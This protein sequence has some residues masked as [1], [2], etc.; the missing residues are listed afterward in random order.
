MRKRNP[1]VPILAALLAAF[2]VV[3][4]APLLFF[5]VWPHS[6]ALHNETEE[7]KERHLLLARNLGSA[8]WRYY[9]DSVS[10]FRFITLE[11][12]AGRAAPF[13]RD[14]L[15]NLN[16][17]H[18][19]IADARSGKVLVSYQA[20]PSPCPEV[21][22]KKRFAAFLS[23][24]VPGEIT[25]SPVMPGP[26][27]KPTLYLLGI[28]GK[29]LQIA[30]L[31]T[32]YFRQLGRQISFGRRGHAAIVDHIGRV[33]AHPLES[34]EEEMRDL[35][36]VSA[37]QRMMAGETGVETFYSPALKGEMIAGLTNVPGPGWGVMV[38]QPIAELEATAANIQ[39]SAIVVLAAGLILSAVIAFVFAFGIV[40][41]LN[42]IT[43][44]AGRMA[45]GDTGARAKRTRAWVALGEIEDL[46]QR[47][48]HMAERVEEAQQREA[49]LRRQAEQ[50]SMAKSDFLANVSHEIRTP[51][52][53][54][55]GMSE[56]LL[57]SRL[58]KRQTGYVRT[59]TSSGKALLTLINDILDL[60]K[61]EAGKLALDPVA[62]D[63]R[64]LVEDVAALLAA[65]AEEKG[66]DLVIRFKPG[67]PERLIGDPGRIR[68]VVTNLAGNA[69]KFTRSGHVLVEVDGEVLER[70]GAPQARLTVAVTDTGE[71]IAPEK[72]KDIFDKFEQADNSTTRRHG[73]T[74]L[75]LAISKQLVEAMGGTVALRSAPGQGSTFSFT[76][77]LP[78]AAQD[79]RADGEAAEITGLKLLLAD[80]LEVSRRVRTE[81]LRGWSVAVTAVPTGAEALETLRRAAAAGDPFRLA[82]LDADL[83]D[84]PGEALA[85]SI[86]GDPSVG[87]TPL[88]L[89][90]SS[91]D[92]GDAERQR[93]AGIEAS[94]AK[95][96]RAAELYEL[97]LSL[98]AARAQPGEVPGTAETGGPAPSETPEAAAAR[99]RVLLAEDNEINRHLVAGQL[100][101]E[102]YDLVPA[103]DGREALRS[104]EATPADFDLILMDLSMPE[105][106]GYEATE[107]IRAFE[108][109]QGLR[110][111]PI[112]GLTARA[113]ESDRRRCLETGMDDYLSKPVQRGDLIATIRKWLEPGDTAGSSAA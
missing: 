36:E 2:L 29:T 3:G 19:C 41:S 13:S 38:P 101:T 8:L 59:I 95:P 96:E 51:M 48:D 75:G 97:I 23:L 77:E 76:L 66:L 11:L 106:D 99:R 93:E 113:M 35:S 92:P 56:L 91:L 64:A 68:Q 17:R 87:P 107:A 42:P 53:G 7:V 32:D 14:L 57:R 54:I 30:A 61:V 26:G 112:V 83:P 44:A 43:L 85:R 65:R 100:E 86:A 10:A 20:A 39:N 55:L 37:V 46:T 109:Q 84:Q 27:G 104:Y 12:T 9:S 24:A 21:V 70:G 62:F 82:V 94:L 45:A 4:A 108:A 33:L 98:A 111:V 80:G 28:D 69:V 89:L 1:R 90:T 18:V 88:L 102:P 50:A 67:L 5:W 60:S 74:G 6:A 40:K 58:D 103:L 78:L 110:R 15:E 81:L 72:Q 47:F 34:W 79:A 71:G 22:P 16:F 31:E 73:G 25:V 49:E 105:M 63:L 52:N